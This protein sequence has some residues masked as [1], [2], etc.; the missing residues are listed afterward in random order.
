M[1]TDL[2]QRENSFIPLRVNYANVMPI[3][4][5]QALLMFPPI[6]IGAIAK[7]W[8]GISVIAPLFDYGSTPYMVIYGAL[9]IGFTFFWVA[10]QFNP[11]QIADDL[12]RQGAYI[13]GI[14][15]GQATSDFL[16]NTMTRCDYDWCCVPDSCGL[17]ADHRDPA[18]RDESVGRE[19]L[20]WR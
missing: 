19:L 12:K 6:L 17:A 13:P 20:R 16:D 8:S 7:K 14:R 11:L 2:H 3:I 15:P 5:G 4:F 18:V 10:N 1:V 9:L